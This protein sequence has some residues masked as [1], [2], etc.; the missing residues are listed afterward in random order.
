M[1]HANLIGYLAAR[2]AGIKIVIWNIRHSN[3]DAKYE[4][5][6]T[7]VINRV[8]SLLSKKVSAI[9]YNGEKAKMA[10][11][12]LGYSN[13]RSYIVENGVDTY[14]FKR[15]MNA[16]EIIHLTMNIPNEAWIILSVSRY[17][18][19]KDIP[20]F[21]KAIEEVK[22][23]QPEIVTIMCGSGIDNDNKELYTQI[24][25]SGL[26]VNRDIFL[27]GIRD[28]LPLL[29]SG[30]DIYVLHSASEAFPNTLVQAMACECVCVSTDVGEAAR[31]LNKEDRI[32]PARDYN[33]MASTILSIMTLLPEERRD[34]GSSN[35]EIIE[36]QF[37]ICEAV[38]NYE[39][40]LDEVV[41]RTLG[42]REN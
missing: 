37:S 8:C 38:R 30:C 36:R 15:I 29:F 35:R 18:P 32:V 17:N 13:R 4:K 40:I 3:I 33:R 42:K 2:I 14:Q 16:R 24:E 7:F 1:Y 6:T 10:H 34:E 5:K 41:D 12:L 28:D 31:I 11:E 26:V 19:I 20:M 23:C 9:L 22:R 27:L 25:K 21:I 39:S